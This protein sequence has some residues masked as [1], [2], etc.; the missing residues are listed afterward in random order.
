MTNTDNDVKAED[1]NQGNDGQASDDQGAKAEDK[2]DGNKEGGVDYKAE[3][4][5]VT[6]Q[7]GKAEHKIE[8]TRKKG[9]GSD[10]GGGKVDKD[11]VEKLASERAA[12]IAKEQIDKFSTGLVEDVVEEGI[13][14]LA[15]NADEATLIKFHY[16][17]TI[18]K[19]GLTRSQIMNDLRRCKLLANESVIANA[20]TEL[21]AA[22]R[23]EQG[24]NKQGMA[25]GERKDS[26]QK[27]VLTSSE[28][29]LA[30]RM[31]ERAAKVAKTVEGGKPYTLEHARKELFAAKNQN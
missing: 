26:V 24:K 15:T 21:A 28:E 30:Q 25:S 19:S 1:G 3:L 23:S 17:N 4:E 27:I 20:N 22:L 2:G 9:E 14:A 11:Q 13:G 5:R 18:Q 31:Y 7:L 8:E 12:Q 16:D 6:K 10:D 29:V